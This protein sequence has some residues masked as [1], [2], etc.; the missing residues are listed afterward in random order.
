MSNLIQIQASSVSY[1][2]QRSH[3]EDELYVN[4]EST[5]NMFA[6]YDGHGGNHVSKF[7]KENMP[8][9]FQNKQL[10]IN[11]RDV[12][13]IFNNLQDK[14]I[15]TDKEIATEVG[16]TSLCVLHD[17]KK[18]QIM[19]CGDCRCILINNENIPTQIT[20]DHKP[21]EQSELQRL[22]KIK[23]EHKV[24][25]DDD[26][27]WRIGPLSVSRSFG[28]ID[29]AP[30]I[31][32]K[33]DII[34]YSIKN[35][36]K[37]GVIACDGLWDVLS[38]EEVSTFINNTHSDTVRKLA[39]YALKKGTTDNISIILFK[40]IHPVNNNKLG[41]NKYIKQTSNQYRSKSLTSSDSKTKS[42]SLTSSDSKTKSR[43]LASSDSK[44]K[45]RSLASSD[46]K[47][48]SRSL[49]SSDSKTKSISIASSDSKTKSRSLT[50]SDSKTKS[51]SLTSSDSKT[52]SRSLASSDSKTKSR[53]LTSSKLLNKKDSMS[54]NN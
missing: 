22:S 23:G 34:N 14:L 36:D 53:S 21:N 28:D 50:S 10:P 35:T 47:T 45:S 25:L 15:K 48:K 9:E 3:N 6:I 39:S 38:N 16:S 1:K 52:K 32:H 13:N 51:R 49:T 42:R 37:Y 43:S 26:D 19:N 20:V 54:K 29:T 5:P 30:Y 27:D 18:L 17:N 24:Y 46:S 7:L 41:G 12:Y 44:T 40:F 31:S 8:S 11:K 4:T 33:P 2:G